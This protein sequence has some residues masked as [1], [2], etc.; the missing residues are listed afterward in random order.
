MKPIPAVMLRSVA[1]EST[2]AAP[3]STTPTRRL[4]PITPTRSAKVELTSMSRNTEVSGVAA[5]PVYD[6]F[7]EG[8]ETSDLMSAK[9]LLDQLA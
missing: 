4:D 6:R 5:P 8:F 7:T 9:G 1:R 3:V 2:V